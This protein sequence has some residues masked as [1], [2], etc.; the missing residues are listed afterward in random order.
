[1]WA[2]PQISICIPVYNG[3][4]FIEMTI[5]SVLEQDFSDFEIVV[6]DNASTDE[7]HELITSFQDSRITIYRNDR[8][9]PAHSNWSEVVRLAKS[10]WTK[11]LCADDLLIPNC[12]STTL[13]YVSQHPEIDVIAAQRNVIDD[14]GRQVFPVRSKFSGPTLLSYDNFV[15]LVARC[16]TNPLG[17]SCCLVWRTDLTKKVGEFSSKW[18]YFIDL[19]YWLRLA[20]HSPVLVIPEHLASFRISST[21]WTSSIGLSSTLEARTFFGSHDALATVS[22]V[23]RSL[24]F[25]KAVNLSLARKVL[26]KVFSLRLRR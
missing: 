10:P 17:E 9:L 20:E 22:R 5:N 7:T 18:N 6:L 25:L 19:D 15:D 23:K 14:I 11:L 2:E 1:M 26:L 13:N 21:S 16:G 3:A 12:L 4:R 24:A 8:V